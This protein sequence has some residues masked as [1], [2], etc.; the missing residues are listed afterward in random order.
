MI[1]GEAYCDAEFRY[2]QSGKFESQIEPY[3][4]R[5]AYSRKLYAEGLESIEILGI[6]VFHIWQQKAPTSEEA[7]SQE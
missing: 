5:V 2:G 4:D 6:P 1:A 7:H 3:P